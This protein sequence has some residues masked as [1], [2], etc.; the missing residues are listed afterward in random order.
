MAKHNRTLLPLNNPNG[1]ANTSEITARDEFILTC[2][3]AG[4]SYRALKE[5]G[6]LPDAE[7]TLRGRYRTLTKNK[8]DR[9][10]RPV[11]TERDV[12]LAP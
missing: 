7:S 8:Q 1:T 12:S 9:V 10:R 6:N 2:R 3:A 4:M 11:W 5:Y